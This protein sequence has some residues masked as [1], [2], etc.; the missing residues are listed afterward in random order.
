MSSTLEVGTEWLIR[1]QSLVL[2]LQGFKLL[3]GDRVE[4]LTASQS[5]L[6]ALLM[7]QQGRVHSNGDI[8]EAVRGEAQV[9]DDAL[10]VL[11]SRVR[12]CLRKLGFGDRYLHSVRGIGYIFDPN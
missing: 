7:G 4:P 6:L 12:T 3:G 5:R 8:G 11:V 2:D 9:S 1:H 10:K